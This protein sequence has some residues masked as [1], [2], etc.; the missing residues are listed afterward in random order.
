M[1]QRKYS[2]DQLN[3]RMMSEA[4]NYNQWIFDILKHHITGRRLLEV[5]AGIGNLTPFFLKNGYRLTCTDMNWQNLK[6]LKENHPKVHTVLDD[7]TH[8]K[9]NSEFDTIICV[10]LLEHI[11]DDINALKKIRSLINYDGRLILIVP[12]VK[13]AF[14]TIDIADGHWRRYDPLELRK[15]LILSGFNVSII[16][17]MNIFGLIGWMW[18]GR[19][20]KK[21]LHRPQ[22]IKLFDVFV[23]LFKTIEDIINPRI[24]LSLIV[25]SSPMSTMNC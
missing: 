2:L 4:P 20:R 21:T 5:G 22:S 10:N 1:T 19:I 16:R 24:G 17:Y 18:E 25:V 3:L 15:K 13:K 14:G 6:E 23:P 9:L 11:K 8:T 12:A 7:I